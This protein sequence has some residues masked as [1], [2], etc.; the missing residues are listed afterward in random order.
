MTPFVWLW[1]FIL[2]VLG[3]ELS[4]N[5]LVLPYEHNVRFKG[6]PFNDLTYGS[7]VLLPLAFMD[8]AVYSL[9]KMWTY[10]KTLTQIRSDN[11][12]EGGIEP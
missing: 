9:I 4:T 8:L 3:F 2:A 5:L 6:T 7:M 1:L 10:A 11:M 12:L